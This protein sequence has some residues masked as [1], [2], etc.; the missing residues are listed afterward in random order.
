MDFKQQLIDQL[1]FMQTSAEAMMRGKLREGV[2][3][4]TSIRVIVHQT[5]QSTSLLSYLNTPNPAMLSTARPISEGD[6][7]SDAGMT[8]LESNGNHI[9]LRPAA[10][11]LG[12][13]RIVP[14]S[15]WWVERV[16]ALNDLALTR[17][18]L[19]LTAANH[20]G[21]A[22]VDP[23]LPANYVALA[24]SLWTLAVAGDQ[25]EKPLQ[26]MLTIWQIGY[27]FG[28]SPGIIALAS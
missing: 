1:L 4:A 13:R 25:Q 27:E 15:E 17:K 21:G 22:H 6:I 20:D 14:F 10:D 3:I 18:Q 11:K 8:I 2:R 7:F 5:G 23:D 12:Q 9:G 26:A 19:V 24:D 28:L 16:Y